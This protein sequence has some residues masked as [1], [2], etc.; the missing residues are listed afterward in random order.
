V[1]RDA[2]LVAGKWEQFESVMRTNIASVVASGA[3][4]VTTSCPACDMMW[5]TVY[6]EWAARLGIDYRSPCATTPS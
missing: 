2:M 4:T 5:R 6:P 3:T 1:L